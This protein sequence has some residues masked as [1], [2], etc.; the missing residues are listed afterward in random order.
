MCRYFLLPMLMVPITLWAQESSSLTKDKLLENI[1]ESFAEE[2]NEETDLSCF[3]EELEE[4]ASH[5]ININTAAKEELERLR[6]LNPLQL[7]NL[8]AYR[9]RTGQIYS[10]NEIQLLDGFTR[11]VTEKLSVFITLGPSEIRVFKYLANEATL[12]AQYTI[13]KASGFIA[14]DKGMKR[15]A[16]IEPKLYFNYRGEKD[17]CWHWGITG[18]N[19]PGETFFSGNNKAGFDF[20]SAHLS[21]SGNKGV[22]KVIAGD[23]QVKSGQGLLFWSGYGGR[24]MT[25]AIGSRY[26]GQGIRPYTSSTEYGFY[27]GVATEL[28]KGKFNGIVFYSNRNADANISAV[29]EEGDTEEVSSQQEMG[30]HRT[31]DEIADKGSLNIQ[32]TGFSARYTASRFTAALN[33]GYQHFDIPLNPDSQL[34]NQYY[35][36]GKDKYG[37]S[38]DFQ[39]ALIIGTLYGELAI[40]QSGATALVAGIDASPVSELSFSILVRDYKKDFHTIG[41]NPFSEFG[42]AMNERGIYSA[43][44][45]F[46]IPGVTLTGYFDLYESYWVKYTSLR[47]IRGDDFALQ[48]NWSVMKQIDLQLRFKHESRNENSFVETPIK[49]DAVETTNRLRLNVSWVP[50][51]WFTVRFRADW[52]SLLKGDS[53]LQGWLLLADATAHLLNDRLT[54]TARLA[55]FD[56]DHYISGIRVYENDLPRSFSFPVYYF[57]GF[58]YYINLNYRLSRA[59]TLCLKLAQTQLSDDYTS[60]GSGDLKIDKN[61]KTEI[62]FQLH[63]KF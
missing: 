7:E 44:N 34:Y 27:R 23:F 38:T 14:D 47:P 63:V 10:L 48:A 31:D 39:K 55:W 18:E 45:L 29:D 1:A 9:K 40:S 49:T 20:Y 5:P 16:G 25:D 41:G 13:E 3:L 12:R 15:F 4:M 50:S 54:A 8:L 30:Y 42:M 32:T 6:L 26:T 53:L 28:E 17:K 2:T 22:R 56:T 60:I 24:K 59:V 33:G 58:H 35:F 46:S 57:N 21:W 51:D 62:K 52:N 11:E 19:D 61:H 37:V 43:A 36:R